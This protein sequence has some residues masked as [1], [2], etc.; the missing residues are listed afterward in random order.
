MTCNTC[1]GDKK[2]TNIKTGEPVCDNRSCPESP[3]NNYLTY[4]ETHIGKN[5]S[6][7]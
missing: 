6:G 1:N 2:A 5:K 7:E 3:M 4:K